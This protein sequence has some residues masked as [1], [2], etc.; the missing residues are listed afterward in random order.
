V[1]QALYEPNT[2]S[3]RNQ[4]LN[5]LFPS[6]MKWINKLKLKDY[7][8]ASH[9]G[10]SLEAKIFV[11][12]YRNLPDDIFSLVIHDSIL[13]LEDQTLNIKQK[14][15]ERTTEIFPLLKEVSDLNNLFK[16]S[17]VSIEDND[18]MENKNLRLL[19]EYLKRKKSDS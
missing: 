4:A 11:E 3:N 8:I 15:I 12:V 2:N 19:A 16:I 17:S 18:L 6:F 1:L 14:L 9:I 13:C 10:Q 7:R 5:K